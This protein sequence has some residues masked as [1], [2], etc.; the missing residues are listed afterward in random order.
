MVRSVCTNCHGLQFTL[1]ALADRKL[2][3][4]NFTGLSSVHIDSIEWAQRRARERSKR[5][6]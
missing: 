4:K 1:D 3:D 5:R 2:I 6:Q